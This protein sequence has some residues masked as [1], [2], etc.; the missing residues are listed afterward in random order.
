MYVVCHAQ[1]IGSTTQP[2]RSIYVMT[3]NTELLYCTEITDEV[4]EACA[5][6]TMHCM[7]RQYAADNGISF[8]DAFF[9]FATSST[10]QVL[11]DFETAV[12]KERPEY[13]RSLFE[14]F[15]ARQYT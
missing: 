5:I 8:E 11:F 3:S 10:Y 15:L 7:V 1:L 14:R 13:I 12:W 9:T 4:K 6:E 2:T